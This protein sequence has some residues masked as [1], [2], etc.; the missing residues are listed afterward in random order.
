M[1]KALI[2]WGGWEGHQPDLVA[3]IFRKMLE[4]EGI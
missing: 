4:P 1:T 2:T 3:E